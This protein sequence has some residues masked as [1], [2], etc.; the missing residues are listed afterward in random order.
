MVRFRAES[1]LGREPTRLESYL[2]TCKAI[3]SVSAELDADPDCKTHITLDDN[4]G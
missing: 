4:G 3:R 1:F 2:Q